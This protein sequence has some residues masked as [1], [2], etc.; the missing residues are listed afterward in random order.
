VG[1]ET[2]ELA[3]VTDIRQTDEEIQEG[4]TLLE[5]TGRPVLVLQGELPMYRRMVI[6]TEGP[7]VAQLE[8]ALVR[9][10]YDVG[11]VDTVF[12][13]STA[14]AVELRE[15]ADPADEARSRN[16]HLAS[17]KSRVGVLCMAEA[18]EFQP[19]CGEE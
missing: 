13:A 1:I 8:R 3:I 5:V 9:L 4:D 16:L 11:Q 15:R 10:G 19:P 6:G 18:I 17:R 14:S 7:D 12:H 2:G